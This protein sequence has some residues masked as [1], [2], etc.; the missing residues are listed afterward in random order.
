MTTEE[1]ISKH[2]NDNVRSLALQSARCSDIDLP[3]AL[4]QIA[5][6]QTARTKLP[7]WAAIDGI[8]YPPHLSMEQCSSEQTARYKAQLALSLTQG[9][10]ATLVD[11]TGGFGVDFSFMAQ[12]FDRAIYVERQSHL[13]EA[14]HHNLLLLGLNNAEVV[15]GDGTVYLERLEHVAM[16]FLDPA[17]RDVHGGKTVAISDCT[18]DVTQL[19]DKL[20][21]KADVVMVKLSPMLDWHK[22]V[23]DLR[24]KVSEVHIVSVAG[25]CKELLLVLRRDFTGCPLVVCVNDNETFSYRE[26]TSLQSTSIGTIGETPMQILAATPIKEYDG[27][28][29]VLLVPNA[30]IMKA[31]CFERLEKTFGVQA[32]SDNS[33]LFLATEVV[34]DFPGKQYAIVGV[35]TL[36]KK[37]L[38]HALQGIT[39]ANI[40]VRNFPLSV[41]ELRKRL[42]LKDG[43]NTYI[44][45]TTRGSREHILYLCTALPRPFS[46]A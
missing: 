42:K 36:N 2:R 43:G 44:F 25:E 15:E 4:D 32:V 29:K 31:G 30:S 28:P 14:V 23:D 22:A 8:V 13:C 41:P 16:L 24:G 35:T 17:R 9:E 39:Q 12:G 7:S 46:N 5:G 40:S 33:H 10:D 18:P 19:E 11:L 3:Y 27:T 20:L 21:A 6:W 1:F 45:A 34:A 26:G 37:E 38:K